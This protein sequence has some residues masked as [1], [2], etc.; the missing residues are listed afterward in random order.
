MPTP[1]PVVYDVTFFEPDGETPLFGSEYLGAIAESDFQTDSDELSHPRPYLGLP[2]NA[3]A[4]ETDFIGGAS[5]IGSV[6]LRILDKRTD[7]ADQTSGILTARLADLRGHRVVFRRYVDGEWRVRLDGVVYSVA[8]DQET[9][10]HYVLELRD[11]RDFERDQRLFFSNHVLFGLDGASGPPI[12]YGALP[13]GGYLLEAVEPHPTTF[14][15]GPGSGVGLF[16]GAIDL[17]VGSEAILGKL[18]NPVHESDGTWRHQDFQVWWRPVSPSPEP[19][20]V[21]RNMARPLGPGHAVS[22]PYTGL[23]LGPSGSD[24]F[25]HSGPTLFIS[26]DDGDDIPGDDEDVEILILA[27]EISEETPFWW[28]GGTLGDLLQ[29]IVAG[30]HTDAV[31]AERYDTAALASFAASSSPARVFLDKPV[32]DRRRWVEEN[33]YR[34]ALRAPALNVDR[35]LRPVSWEP[36]DAETAVPILDGETLQPIG[37]LIASIEG[38]IGTVEFAYTREHLD[39]QKT[40]RKKVPKKFLGISYGSRYEE[41]ID[42]ARLDWERLERTEVKVTITDPNAAPGAGVLTIAPITI[43]SIGSSDG[44]AHNDVDELGNQIANRWAGALFP[45]RRLGLKTLEIDATAT[46][47]NLSRNVGDFVRLRA[48]WHGDETDG[49]RGLREI[50]QIVAMSESDD[51]SKVR[52]K[53]ELIAIPDRTA[54][55]DETG[56]GTAGDDCL[57]GGTLHPA[58]GGLAVRMFQTPGR[59][60]LENTCDAE[61]LVELV[62]IAG[63]G[64]GGNTGT[65]GGGGAGGVREGGDL[66]T[67]KIAAGATIPIDVGAGGTAGASGEDSV[68][69]GDAD[70]NALD[71]D[72]D[73]PDDGVR[74]LGGGHGGLNDAVGA[75]GGSGGGG[76]AAPPISGGSTQGG[77]SGSAGQGN[78]GGSGIDGGGLATGQRSVGGGGGSYAGAGTAG[79]TNFAGGSSIAG[80]GAPRT[81]I[82][83]WDGLYAGGGGTGGVADIPQPP[84]DA[85]D[86]NLVQAGAAGEGGFGAGGGGAAQG[87]GSTPGSSGVVA[88]RY[89]GP[90]ANL[91]PPTVT[92]VEIDDLNQAEICVEETGWPPDPPAGLQVRVE[93]ALNATEPDADSGLWRLVDYLDAPGCVVTPPIPAGAKVWGRARAEAPDYKPSILSDA[94]SADAPETPGFRS[95][96]LTVTADGVATLAW[97]PND[98]TGAVR[99]RRKIHTEGE[100]TTRPLTLVASLDAADSPYEFADLVPE[101]SFI[102][103]DLEA[104]EDN[105]YALQGTTERRSEQNPQRE[106]VLRTDGLDALSDVVLT[107]PQPNDLLRQNEYG[108][109]VNVPQDTVLEETAQSLSNDPD[110]FM[111]GEGHF[112]PLPNLSG[113]TEIVA[114][115]DEDVT[116]S[117]A[118]QDDDE[119]FF[120]V[121][122]GETYHV[123]LLLVISGSD[124]AVDMRTKWTFPS[125]DGFLA[126]ENKGTTGAASQAFQVFGPTATTTPSEVAIGTESSHALCVAWQR[127]MISCKASGNVQFQHA[128]NSAALGRVSRR[129]AGSVLRYRRLT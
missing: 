51:P 72:V 118:L 9:L 99:V 112:V 79:D 62:V 108:E 93:Y 17:P 101:G 125:S 124:N 5:R 66:V 64:S 16:W 111:N 18:G 50:A 21:L 15:V 36:P 25:F 65:G 73:D 78:A 13:G 43:R 98:F 32:T 35:E 102:T 60:Y 53:L 10:V 82:P 75:N 39:P 41:V 7:L 119:L 37:D 57:D 86:S 87:A 47:E 1:T 3:I 76:G 54:D 105:T 12:D 109:W 58:G 113:W 114:A 88:V 22:P 63:G 28:D 30:D 90:V 68:W 48:E 96:Q 42:D 70:G 89:S 46:I 95:V 24:S 117:A 83:G 71:P 14:H 27:V 91:Q 122:S 6:Q 69:W 110:E 129:K 23:G 11:G 126:S 33:I 77:G 40:A 104:W 100:S 67:R 38:A 31:P 29:E 81:L 45:R 120:P 106:I 84:E 128:N 55:D 103:V 61:V 127:M 123:E 20:R 59:F 2:L 74:A 52:F 115:V 92:S 4:S 116:N 44:K 26:S 121:A 8:A 80:T 94:V 34:A 97:D 56:T 49:V 85:N 107:D 19:Y